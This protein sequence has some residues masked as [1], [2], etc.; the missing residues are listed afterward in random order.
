MAATW[1]SA[2]KKTNDNFATYA[3]GVF[4]S[5]LSGSRGHGGCATA[6]CGAMCDHYPERCGEVL[7][8]RHAATSGCPRGVVAPEDASELALV[9]RVLVS[10]PRICS[11]P[12]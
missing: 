4:D 2:E 8:P 12:S 3:L 7:W 6:A 10:P 1:T 11:C 9:A 5:S